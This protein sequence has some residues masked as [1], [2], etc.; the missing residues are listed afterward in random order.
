VKI[1][2]ADGSLLDE[3]QH[4]ATID[5]AMKNASRMGPN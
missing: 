5:P 3:I 1:S 4:S 2:A